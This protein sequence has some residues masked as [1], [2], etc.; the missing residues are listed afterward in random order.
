MTEK[1]KESVDNGGVFGT[2]L[3]ELS[4][5][6][7]CLHHELLIAKPDTYGFDLKSVRLVHQYISIRKQKVDNA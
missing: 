1:W 2:L 5:A 6:F 7:D 3:A 4:I